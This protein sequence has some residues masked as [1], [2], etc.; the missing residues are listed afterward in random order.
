MLC[1]VVDLA[2]FPSGFNEFGFGKLCEMEGKCGGRNTQ[3]ARNFSSGDAIFGGLHE[4]AENVDAIFLRESGND[5]EGFLG[6]HFFSRVE[7]FTDV[8]A[9]K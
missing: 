4:E 7:I 3:C 5:F 1:G 9:R 2:P 6:L 8:I